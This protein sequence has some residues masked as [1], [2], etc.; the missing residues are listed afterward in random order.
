VLPKLAAGLFFLAVFL[1]ANGA[2]LG[3]TTEPLEVV[4]GTNR[5]I[6]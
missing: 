3:R 4:M 6:N 5:A 1:Q 2:E